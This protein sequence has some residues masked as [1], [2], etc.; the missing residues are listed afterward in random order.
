MATQIHMAASGA[1]KSRRAEFVVFLIDDDASVLLAL[2]RLLRAAGYKV[3]PF[4][5]SEGF[6]NEHDP[7]VA[8]CIILDLAMPSMNGLVLQQTLAREGVD[9]PVIF[10]TGQGTITASVEAMKAGAIDFLCKPVSDLELLDAIS[11][12][13]EREKIRLR[14][15]I[16]R[17]S[18]LDLVKTLTPRQ[19]EVLAHV[20]A[21]LNNAQISAAIGCTIKT[22]KV[23]RGRM[24]KKMG[25]RTVAELVR[26]TQKARGLF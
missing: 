1:E 23:H 26:I 19:R 25:V 11:L 22:V 3:K 13:E 15:Q 5:S 18:V 9:R 16:E 14:T 10:L 8:G 21:G 20:I 7:S 4:S 6:L 2:T 12:A 24:M 17:Q